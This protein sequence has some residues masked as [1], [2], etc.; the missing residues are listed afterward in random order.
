MDPHSRFSQFDNKRIPK[1]GPQSSRP[2]VMESKDS[3]KSQ[4][5]RKPSS[6]T[7][8]N[9]S[10][11]MRRPIATNSRV[12]QDEKTRKDMYL[13]FVNNALHQKSL[14]ITES[15]D[16]LVSQFNLKR[17][18]DGLPFPQPAQLRL[19]ILALSH[20]VSR[21]ERN[22]AALVESIVNLPWAS[23]D[24]A[25]VKSY[26][27]F[28]GMLLSARP[29]YLSLILSKITQG[30]TYQSTIQMLTPSEN[31]SSSASNPAGPPLTRRIIYDRLHYLL[32]H[33]LSLIP[34]LPSTLMPLLARNFPHKRQNTRSQTTY[35]KN[36]LRV[37]WYCPELSDR[38]LELVIDRAIQIDVEIQAEIDDIEAEISDGKGQSSDIFDIDL[39]TV[40][41]QET[42]GG[43]SDSDDSDSSDDDEDFSDLSSEGGG[44]FDD[45]THKR[46]DLPMDVK[47]IAEMAKKL[48]AILV[49]VFEHFQ[50]FI[51]D[52][53]PSMP[54][55]SSRPIAVTSGGSS[56]LPELPPLDFP[57]TMIVGIPS[58]INLSDFPS[59]QSRSPTPTPA[60]STKDPYVSSYNTQ[61]QASVPSDLL[62]PK[63]S[64][65]GSSSSSRLQSYFPTL[66]SIFDRLILRTFKSR[67]TQFLLFWYTSLEVE[68]AD[69][70]MG[71]LVERALYSAPPS[72]PTSSMNPSTT[73]ASSGAP[74][75]ITRTA[76]ASYIGSF[77]S[78]AH[79]VDGAGT[80]RVM[81]VLCEWLE[82]HLDAVDRLLLL[83]SSSD[84]R[85]GSTSTST[86]NILGTQNSVFHAVSQAVFLIFCFRWRDLLVDIG[87]S[88]S[89]SQ[90]SSLITTFRDPAFSTDPPTTGPGL[91]QKWLPQLNVVRRVITSVMNPLRVCSP[92]VAGQFARVAHATG[93]A[94]CYSILES[95][96][97]VGDN[98]DG[99]GGKSQLLGVDRGLNAELNTF[100]PFDPY[101]LPRSN[102][103]IED[104]YRSWADVAIDDDEENDD[105]DEDEEEEEDGNKD[106]NGNVAGGEDQRMAVSVEQDGL[107]KL[108]ITSSFDAMS[109]SPARPGVQAASEHR[110]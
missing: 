42:S 60:S 72:L 73:S 27:V 31:T 87:D 76:A 46:T 47:H 98:D 8:P 100:F 92:A 93:F 99:S 102:R 10:L 32:Q 15:F 80:R 1:A 78:R 43:E 25:T 38:I 16:E 70:F 50:R 5:P 101:A 34:T 96:K 20:V 14:G 65:S 86:P 13:S 40:I 49:L 62:T 9:A 107:R 29:E 18:R 108:G 66:L 36:L 68:F 24:T 53:P 19:W 45:D 91:G 12:K 59:I 95:N 81:S 17:S 52:Q 3:P 83:P 6:S 51:G 75:A 85:T 90:P 71:M 39:D 28:I 23:M 84:L 88:D 69:V 48:D 44:D 63:P 26:T 37:C 106:N 58:L 35:I 110:T 77:V 54:L 2:R 97:R 57:N 79:I 67:Y 61:L 74:P 22:H 7:A 64:L 109:I 89:Q 105:E 82:A 104:K 103:F 55:P 4:L 94:Y 30:F 33:L 41:G 11:F 21:L 56:P